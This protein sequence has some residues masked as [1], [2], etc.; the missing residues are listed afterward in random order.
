MKRMILE[1]EYAPEEKEWLIK[2]ISEFMRK[3]GVDPSLLAAHDV[4][5]EVL[6]AR[7]VITALLDEGKSKVP[8][9]MDKKTKE[10]IKQTQLHNEALKELAMAMSDIGYR[11]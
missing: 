9:D 2:R 11:Q 3:Y 10:Y 1:L 8:V 4:T 6:K 5:E 7:R